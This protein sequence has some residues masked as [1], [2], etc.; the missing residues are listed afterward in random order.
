MDN[1]I[2]VELDEA[3]L[4]ELAEEIHQQPSPGHWGT[5]VLAARGLTESETVIYDLMS[6]AVDYCFWYGRAHIRPNEASAVKMYD[7]LNE[8]FNAWVVGDQP[9]FPC[10]PNLSPNGR[11]LWHFVALMAENQFPLMADRTRHVLELEP[12]MTV[13]PALLMESAL[14]PST[15]DRLHDLLSL[16]MRNCPGF[17]ED[18]FFKRALL[19]FM[20]LNRRLGWF[21]AEI[22]NLPIPADYQIPR[23]L[24]DRGVLR[25]SQSLSMKVNIGELIPPGS[26]EECEIRAASI[27]ACD[28]ISELSGWTTSAVDY[29]LWTI[30]NTCKDPFHLTVTPNY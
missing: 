27:L 15:G 29:Y 23:V 6:C 14:G 16:L 4:R 12:A 25:Y 30:R 7:L 17:A 21:E 11:L 18:L 10:R 24:R 28:R 5:P 1:P 20:Q 22:H 2:H 19:F 8:A 9:D 26:S 3:A 13:I